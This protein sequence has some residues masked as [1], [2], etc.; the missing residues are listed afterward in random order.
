[1]DIILYNILKIL[2]KMKI[3]MK[4]MEQ[5]TKQMLKLFNNKNLKNN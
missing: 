2:I 3:K 5:I 4:K 1:M